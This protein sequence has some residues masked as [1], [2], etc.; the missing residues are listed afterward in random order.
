[1]LFSSSFRTWR[2]IAWSQSL[3]VSH[4]RGLSPKL[5]K[6]PVWPQRQFAVSRSK[7]PQGYVWFEI[8]PV[9]KLFVDEEFREQESLFISSYGPA[10]SRSLDDSRASD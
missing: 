1:M 4:S 10:A 5:Q 2:I 6:F 9:Y 8:S 3:S 7:A